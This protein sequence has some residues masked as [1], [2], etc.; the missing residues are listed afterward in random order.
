MP[1]LLVDDEVDHMEEI[2]K[3]VD[4]SK[5][6]LDTSKQIYSFDTENSIISADPNSPCLIIPSHVSILYNLETPPNNSTLS[7]NKSPVSNEQ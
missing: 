5:Q 3:Q 6:I 1:S 2:S 4:P 7:N